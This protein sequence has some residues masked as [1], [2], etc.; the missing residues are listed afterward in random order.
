VI[1]PIDSAHNQSSYQC[2]FG[3]NQIVNGLLQRQTVRS[4]VGTLTV[5]GKRFSLYYFVGTI[6]AE[7]NLV[8]ILQVHHQ[9]VV[10]LLLKFVQPHCLSHGMQIFIQ[11]VELL[12]N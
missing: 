5:V 1:G 8:V 7:I 10:L 6:E 2:V 12:H 9:L 11:C 3:I 4:N